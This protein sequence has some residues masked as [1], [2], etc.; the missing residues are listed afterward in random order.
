MLAYGFLPVLSSYQDA[1]SFEHAVLPFF[2]TA[3]EH[4]YEYKSGIDL[5]AHT[6]PFVSGSAFSMFASAFV[7]VASMVTGNWSWYAAIPV[8]LFLTGQGRSPVGNHAHDLRSALLDVCTFERL[9]GS[10]VGPYDGNPN[11]MGNTTY[12]QLL[13]ERRVRKVLFHMRAFLSADTCFYRGSED[14]RWVYVRKYSSRHFPAS[15]QPVI[16]VFFN[17]ILVSIVQNVQLFLLNSP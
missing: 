6:N 8:R 10:P 11:C 17:L 15:L 5:Y 14:Y 13:A 9:G 1:A 7:F 3:L 4:I 16:L 2:H 12:P